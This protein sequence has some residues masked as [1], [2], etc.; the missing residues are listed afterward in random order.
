MVIH[1][2]W[3]HAEI[4]N[5]WNWWTVVRPERE[6]RYE[7]AMTRWHVSFCADKAAYTAA[8]PTWRTDG[9]TAHTSR[10]FPPGRDW[11]SETTKALWAEMEKDGERVRQAEDDEMLIRLVKVRLYLWT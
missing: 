4:R 5:L 11:E 3:A 8:H 1:G 6:R 2:A 10:V 9:C 7:E